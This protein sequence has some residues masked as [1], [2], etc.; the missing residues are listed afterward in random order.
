MNPEPA[1]LSLLH[2]SPMRE[3][4]Q[5]DTTSHIVDS[6]IDF[7]TIYQR[8]QPMGFRVTIDLP[9]VS[10]DDSP[11]FAIRVNPFIEPAYMV[12]P[13]NASSFSGLHFRTPIYPIPIQTDTINTSVTVTR[14]DHPPAFS[15]AAAAHRFWRGSIMYRLRSV[16]NFITSAYIFA[17]M[18][19][20][21][22]AT[23][24]SLFDSTG[25]AI[26][27]N[28]LLNQVRWIPGLNVS[29]R[30]WMSNAYVMSDA[31]MNRHLEIEAPFEYP[32]QYFDNYR[33]IFEIT[34]R[35]Q[36][37]DNGVSE[38]NC[39]DNFILVYN[40]GPISSPTAG[41]QVIFEL[42]YAPGPDFEF[43]TE[44]AFSRHNLEVNLQNNF[45]LGLVQPWAA[46][47]VLYTYPVAS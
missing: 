16:T 18:A 19:R 28:S 25:A 36:T 39:P 31:S 11:L 37:S 2:V 27:G 6:D 45:T 5:K 10:D 14:Y 33:N 38:I 9:F 12:I 26:A 8:W 44:Y 41:A 4:S 35:H 7:I 13:S 24:V 30:R 21:L 40:R 29:P 43:S 42:E 17:C 20:N 3:D 34:K 46:I 32:V 15:V 47:N 23:E 22:V 1:D